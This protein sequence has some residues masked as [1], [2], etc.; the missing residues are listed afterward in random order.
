MFSVPPYNFGPGVNGLI[1]VPGICKALHMFLYSHSDILTHYLIAVGTCIGAFVGGKC[2]DWVAQR[3]ARRNGGKFLPEARLILL[4]VPFVLG[5]CGLLMFGIGAQKQMHWIVLFI[6]F[7]MISIVPA[8]P[9]IAMTYVMDSYFEVAAEGLLVV[10][11]VKN[12]V[13]F[14]FS[15]GFI[16][17]TSKVGYSTVFS[18]LQKY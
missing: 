16:P 13:A 4:A 15:Y 11:G 17:W 2:T 18:S 5:P 10:N 7:G 3:S 12:T 6:G 9:S 14:A 8:A 1:C